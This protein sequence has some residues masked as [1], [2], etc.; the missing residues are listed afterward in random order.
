MGYNLDYYV[1]MLL[2]PIGVDSSYHSCDFGKETKLTQKPDRPAVQ[3]LT[4]LDT[5]EKICARW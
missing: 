4:H 1:C 5:K 2:I 3:V